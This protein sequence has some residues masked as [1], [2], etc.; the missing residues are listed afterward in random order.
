MVMA[1]TVSPALRSAS[2][3]ALVEIPRARLSGRLQDEIFDAHNRGYR[4]YG[5]QF[6]ALFV[7]HFFGVRF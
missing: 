2:D 4:E 5:P 7:E 1:L 6:V 3:S